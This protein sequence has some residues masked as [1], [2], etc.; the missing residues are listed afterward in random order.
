MQVYGKAED[1]KEFIQ[2][3][4]DSEIDEV[5]KQQE[6][7]SAEIKEETSRQI[8]TLTHKIAA[9]THKEVAQAKSKTLSEEK[10]NAKKQFEQSREELIN[11]IFSEVE[12]GLPSLAHSKR[13][14]TYLTKKTK[15]L[16]TK[17]FKV[18]ADSDYY[19]KMFSKHTKSDA[20]GIKLTSGDIIY[21]FT[22]STAFQ[23]NK[24]LLRREA[25]KVLFR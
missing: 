14:T 10:L 1:L 15:T 19:K 17:H 23:A 2:K 25:S 21:D 16:D 18:L 9:Q 6:Q 8:D 20:I 7:K 13:Y 12:N 11:Y 3:K 24:E 5:K 4:Y 22:L